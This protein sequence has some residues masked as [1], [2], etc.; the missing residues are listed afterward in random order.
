MNNTGFQTVIFFLREEEREREREGEGGRNLMR[1][2]NIENGMAEDK[3]FD[4]DI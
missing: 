3:R 2:R 1:G 4:L